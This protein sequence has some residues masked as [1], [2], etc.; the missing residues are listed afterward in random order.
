M[1]GNN[2]KEKKVSHSEGTRGD[3]NQIF[4][5]LI[6]TD[7]TR[8]LFSSPGNPVMKT[9]FSLCGKTTQGKPCSGPVLALYGI[10]VIINEQF[11]IKW[12][13]PDCFDKKK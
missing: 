2:F 11:G 3:K 6:T 10:A 8:S 9:G 12:H 13:R 7:Y 5:N 4:R 1:R